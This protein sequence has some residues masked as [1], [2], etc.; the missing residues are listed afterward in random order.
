MIIGKVIRSSKEKQTYKA[1]GMLISS[2]DIYL[3]LTQKYNLTT[4]GKTM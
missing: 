4:L 3:T 1:V 2:A